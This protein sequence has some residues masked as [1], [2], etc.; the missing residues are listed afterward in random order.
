MLNGCRY[1][2]LKLQVSQIH[3]YQVQVQ[4]HISLQV[5]FY[6]VQVQGHISLQV[7][8]YQVKVQV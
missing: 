6:Q 5:H 1:E 7:H 2:Q 8:F 4:G 3:H